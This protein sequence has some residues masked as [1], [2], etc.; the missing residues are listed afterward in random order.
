[1]NFARWV[2][3]YGPTYLTG[4]GWTAVTAVG[5]AC[6]ALIWGCALLLIRLSA[7]RWGARSVDAYVQLFRNTPVLLPIYLI[8]FAFPMIGLPWPAVVCGGLALILQ[9]G[10]YISEILRGSVNAI[11]RVQF[12]AARSIGLAPWSTFRK[13]VLPQVLVYSIPALGNQTVLLL[14]DTSLLS[15]ISITELTM[16]AKLLTEQTGAAYEAFIVVALLYLLLV[17][18][19]EVFFRVTHRAVRWR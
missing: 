3:I 16:Q 12:D 10:A 6:G 2:A 5:A 17:S 9:N 15:A 4:L 18:G 14:K 8:Y 7:G 1:M 13:V 19:T 11:D